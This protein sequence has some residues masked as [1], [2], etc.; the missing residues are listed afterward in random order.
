MTYKSYRTD[1]IFTIYTEKQ[2]LQHDEDLLQHETWKLTCYDML[3]SH[4]TSFSLIQR[5]LAGNL[6]LCSLLLLD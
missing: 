1:I 5:L 2:R 4:V 6:E 3:S